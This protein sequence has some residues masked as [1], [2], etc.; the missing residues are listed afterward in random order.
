MSRSGRCSNTQA[1]EIRWRPQLWVSNGVLR[2]AWRDVPFLALAALHG[3]VLTE[4]P[5]APVIAIGLWWNSNTI[6]HNF[7]HRP[8]FH[9]RFLNALFSGYLSLLLGIPQALWRDRHLAHHAGNGWRP[10]VSLQLA[11][12]TALVLCLFTTLALLDPRFL[13]MVYLPGY[14]I[15]LGLC[16]LQGYYEHAGGATS[17]YGW[18]YNLICF[19]DGYHVEH[20]ANPGIHWTQLPQQVDPG[21]KTSRW[22][23][24]LRWLDGLSLETLE[25]IVLRFGWLQRL[26]LRSHRRAFCAL[27]PQL[28]PVRRAAI[29]GGG[30]FPRTALILRELL[31]DAHII[32]I[33][34]NSQNLETA[35]SRIGGNFEFVHDRYTSGESRDCDLLVIPLSFEGDR[36]SIYRNPPSRAVLV[37]DWIWRRHGTGRIVSAALLK[38]LNL[39]T[40]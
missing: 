31:P 28:P 6:S 32:I 16:A 30:L 22:P 3:V 4:A 2:N 21:T 33:D 27:V 5:A 34:A 19:N 29:V 15:G 39:V 14:G 17:H 23:P 7:I 12:E 11:F 37:H 13:L 10:R 18:I 26:V 35:R 40:Q 8:F 1:A 9:S 38:R 24:L 25:K 36:T 20:H